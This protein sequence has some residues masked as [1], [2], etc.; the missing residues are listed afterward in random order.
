[1]QFEKPLTAIFGATGDMLPCE[2]ENTPDDGT[3]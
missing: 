3:E 1:V 2:H